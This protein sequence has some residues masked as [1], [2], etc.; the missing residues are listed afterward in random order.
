MKKILRNASGTSQLSTYVLVGSIWNLVGV[1]LIVLCIDILQIRTWL[2]GLILVGT[3]FLGKYVMYH[4]L[5]KIDKPFLSY[6]FISFWPS[7]VN[8]LLL[9]LFVDVFHLYGWLS[10]IIIAGGMFVFRYL[11]WYPTGIKKE[12]D[13][14]ISKKTRKTKTNLIHFFKKRKFGLAVIFLMLC[15]LIFSIFFIF[16]GNTWLDEAGYMYD[17]W[18][19]QQGETPYHDFWVKTT[20]LMYYVYGLVQAGVGFT[21]Y[22]GRAL[23]MIFLALFLCTL[24]GF[25]KN[26]KGSWAGLLAVALIITNMFL[27]RIYVAAG[28]YVLTAFL[29]ILCL[30]ILST[31]W[32]SSK[33]AFFATT[34]LSLAF[35]TRA[36]IFPLLLIFPF[37]FLIFEKE[38]KKSFFISLGT[39]IGI[40]FLILFPFLWVDI[41]VTLR[42]VF[43]T[44]FG[45]FFP[46]LNVLNLNV[47]PTKLIALLGSFDN[48]IH[49]NILQFFFLLVVLPW[50]LFLGI[51]KLHSL[52]TKKE[53][54]A[55]FKQRKIMVILYVQ[56]AL[57]VFVFFI[58]SVSIAYWTYAAPYVV[59]IIAIGAVSV[60]QALP[61]GKKEENE[62]LSRSFFVWMIIAGLVVS[63]AVFSF[64]DVSTPAKE[65]DLER[66]DRVGKELRNHVSSDDKII[67]FGNVLHQL[68]ASKL[69]TYPALTHRQYLFTEHS[70][71]ELVKK[72]HFFNYEL[73]T[74]WFNE[75]DVVLIPT[76][77]RFFS[78]YGHTL[79]S[80]VHEQLDQGFV[81]Q[82]KIPYAFPTKYNKKDTLLVYRKSPKTKIP[83]EAS[84][85]E[86]SLKR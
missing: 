59:A 42:G 25:V 51:K 73:L 67:I 15:F 57:S 43:G 62:N 41:P 2:S 65:S 34:A 75:S 46:S 7:L 23:S 78:F 37:Y 54:F 9:M 33:K 44:M 64:H 48:L 56:A 40:P 69:K 81:L 14:H 70:D 85:P 35:L 16:F 82:T 80:F 84:Q 20:P 86:I 4:K 53:Q 27:M 83:T 19:I 63:P 6:V 17:T 1:L 21:F 61:T 5:K 47:T 28:P 18:L 50:V 77:Q 49:F 11:G 71:T 29:Q 13:H 60:Y 12:K 38:K 8:V 22:S 26:V 74:A 55:F 31:T 52:N 58:P 66:I 72:H 45:S 76:D 36:N 30:Y 3:V 39:M 24:Y 32:S 79:Q 10:Q 68:Y